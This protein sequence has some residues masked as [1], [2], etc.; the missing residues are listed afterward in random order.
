V[1]KREALFGDSQLFF[2]LCFLLQPTKVSKNFKNAETRAS[3]GIARPARAKKVGQNW[4]HEE[5]NEAK[6]VWQVWPNGRKWRNEKRVKK[7]SAR[8]QK[9][10][11][12]RIENTVK[13]VEVVESYNMVELTP[14]L[15]RA[16]ISVV[17]TVSNP[18]AINLMGDRSP[19]YVKEGFGS[20]QSCRKHSS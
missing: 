4:P 1:G 17:N 7:P 16:L 6:K 3:T 12:M 9:S 2:P 20:P 14:E 5:K 13:R 10:R 15:M 11:A 8:A 19:L 18:E